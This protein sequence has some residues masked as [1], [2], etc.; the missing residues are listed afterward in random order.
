MADEFSY[1][2]QLG[3]QLSKRIYYGK[4]HPPPPP[5][6]PLVM[7]RKKSDTISYVPTALM[8]YAVITEPSIVDNPDIRSYQPY[9]HGRCEPPAL[10]PIHMQGINM[11][12]DCFLDT[13][14]V[15]MTGTW[16]L[17]CVD[18]SKTCDC[19]IAV[20]MGEQVNFHFICSYFWN[21]IYLYF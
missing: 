14:F 21:L 9:V 16:R 12:I 17:H 13:A 1:S 6:A 5:P 20:P 2:V 7:D 18:A 15:N 4:N 19:R 11:E 8:V 3:L 10:I